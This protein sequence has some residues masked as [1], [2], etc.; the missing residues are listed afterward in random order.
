MQLTSSPAA[1][2]PRLVAINPAV[3]R[4]L[5]CRSATINRCSAAFLIHAPYIIPSHLWT[6][7]DTCR[8]N[9]LR[10]CRTLLC[11]SYFADECTFQRPLLVRTSY[12]EGYLLRRRTF[13]YNV[14]RLLEQQQDSH[15]E[16]LQ[17]NA[18][19]AAGIS[20]V[21]YHYHTF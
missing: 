12:A 11:T 4:R 17:R 19:C 5:T 8:S 13:V 16:I 21:Q 1:I 20:G 18:S 7:P 15:K 10:Y 9:I 2:N 6:R 14:D 3:K